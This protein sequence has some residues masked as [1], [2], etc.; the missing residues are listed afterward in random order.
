MGAI[1]LNGA[2]IGD[3][4]LIGAGALVTEGKIFPDNSVIIGTPARKIRDVDEATIR[5]NER[6]AEIY[7][8]RW[9]TYAS[10]LKRLP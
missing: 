5:L 1:V 3:N 2:R 8:N 9:R 10:G 7:F 6:A 4:C